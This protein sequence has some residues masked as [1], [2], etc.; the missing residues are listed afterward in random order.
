MVSNF[1]ITG[2][3]LVNLDKL[4]SRAFSLS[5]S[6][7]LFQQLQEYMKPIQVMFICAVHLVLGRC[8]AVVFGLQAPMEQKFNSCR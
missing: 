4:H 6:V 3:L 7:C 1:L 2:N 5:R 8:T